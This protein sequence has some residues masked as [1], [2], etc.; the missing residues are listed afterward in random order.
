MNRYCSFCFKS[1][2]E[3]IM[4]VGGTGVF[5]CDMCIRSSQKVMS[6]R[7]KI[8]KENLPTFEAQDTELLLKHLPKAEKVTKQAS[9]TLYVT[10]SLLRERKVSWQKIGDALG[11]S[12]QAACE[13]FSE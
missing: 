11:I 9:E 10:V 5:I 8:T 13:R 12:R 7:G 3:V 4:L 1:M 2:K 6:T